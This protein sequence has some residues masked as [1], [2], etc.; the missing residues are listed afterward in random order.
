[1]TGDDQ[2]FELAK[3]RPDRI[4]FAGK[5]SDQKLL[6]YYRHA[7]IFVFPSLYEGV[8][9][10][11]LEAMASRCPVL[12]SNQASI[13]EYCGDAV[14]YFNPFD[15]EDLA[16]KI[17]MILKDTNLRKS[18]IQSGDQHIKNFSWDKCASEIVTLIKKKIL[19]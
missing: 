9:L 15:P 5:V 6:Q 10:P 18:L 8:G 11:P 13:P 7:S 12:T 3:N 2:V 14:M 16:E 17:R 1:M 19:A 4:H